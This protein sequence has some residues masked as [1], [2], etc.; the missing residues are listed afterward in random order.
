MARHR[1][2]SGEVPDIAGDA[3]ARA[4]HA[5]H[6]GHGPCAVGNEIQHQRRGDDVETRVGKRQILRVGDLEN[7]LVR[8]GLFARE[9]DLRRGGIDGDDSAG[10]PAQ[11]HFG[12]DAR[13]AAG[14]EPVPA[15]RYRQPIEKTG[16]DGAG[17][18]AHE[19]FIGGAVGEAEII[20]AAHLL[21]LCRQL[22]RAFGPRLAAAEIMRPHVLRRSACG[23][24]WAADW[25][26]RHIYA[27]RGKRRRRPRRRSAAP[28][29]RRTPSAPPPA[30]A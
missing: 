19:A 25:R 13:A 26:R 27:H 12:E 22:A 9:G 21:R 17:P 2:R 10:A 1:K 18:A 29:D 28:A 16:A 7:H 24:G 4:R 3:A 20:H 23:C 30:D 8:Q 15:L 6:L 14:V 11:Q 5:P